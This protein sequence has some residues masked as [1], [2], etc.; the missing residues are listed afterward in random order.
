MKRGYAKFL[1]VMVLALVL[2]CINLT[3]WG[4]QYDDAFSY[5]LARQSFANI[6]A[7]T[8]ADTMPPLYYFLLHVW[9]Q[10]SHNIWF[11]RL[12]SVLLSLGIVAFLYAIVSVC[13]G[14][15]AGLWA[16]L[17][18][19]ISPLEI[20]HAQDVRMYA[21]VAFC[22]LGYCYCFVNIDKDSSA[23]LG[24]WIGLVFFGAAAMYSHNLAGF[25][26]IVPDL[27]LLLT[28]KYRLLAKLLAAQVLIGV[29]FIP[30][31]FFVPN[32]IAKIQQA[33]WTPRPGIIEVLQAIIMLS[34]DLPLAGVWLYV[35]AI[36]SIQVFVMVLI[37]IVRNKNGLR[38]DHLL[39]VLLVFV[40]PILLFIVSYVM[41]PVFVARGF[42]VST[43]I[44]DGL[45]GIIVSKSAPKGA[46]Y[47]LLGAA[48]L[49]AAVTLPYQYTFSEFP[50]SPYQ[51]M[52]NSFQE[53]VPTG[54]LVLHDNKLSFFPS[55]YYA[56]QLEQAFLPD[57]SGSSNDTLAPAT[58]AAMGIFP[59]KDVQVATQDV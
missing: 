36:L 21:L 3:H 28:K 51:S 57:V 10:I 7:G 42:L 24:W 13:A 52:V 4:I 50:R 18:A 16:G 53:S 38:T 35:G 46:G 2:R 55:Y 11:L 9:M 17:L 15:A 30:W 27:Y 39:L 6:I 48:V 56:P 1:L 12:L 20:Y 34:A 45:A 19:A 23:K 44:Y 41:R 33:F 32:Q 26:I 37:E 8:A 58:Q 40:P 22:L 47:L 5:F 31:L 25:V 54:S 14:E 43:V 29:A 59:V 49:A